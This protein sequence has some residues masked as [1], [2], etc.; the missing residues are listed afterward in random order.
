MFSKPQDDLSFDERLEQ[1]GAWRAKLALDEQTDS[2]AFRAWLDADAANASAWEESQASWDL[3]VTHGDTHQL[4]DASRAARDQAKADL[5]RRR[6]LW[7]TALP[8]A[9]VLVL[10]F[11]VTMS[12]ALFRPAQTF[13]TAGARR[14]VVLSD[15]STVSLDAGT[16]L[17][18]R[19]RGDRRDLVLVRGQ[20]AFDVAHDASRP[21]AVKAGAQRVTALGTRFNIDLVGEA[22]RITLMEG[23]VKVEP[24]AASRV[25][26]GGHYGIH[27]RPG[28]QLVAG[29][30]DLGGGRAPQVVAVDATKALAWKSGQ[31]FFEDELLGNVVA[32][33]SRYTET[34]VEVRDPGLAQRRI[35][36]MF[37]AGDIATFLD[38]VEHH[39]DAKAVEVS[40]GRVELRRK[41]A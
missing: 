11:V 27:L 28:Q 24:L 41:T 17:E 37:I 18:V 21:F 6:R 5:V 39:L 10:V 2:P 14:D 22:A 26:T 32:R 20:A 9:A 30:S 38:A 40:P 36:G 3:F 35:S 31:L 15:G 29:A 25:S 33:V 34:K 19:F 13:E 16:K 12:A 1:A 4:L 8:W 23:R 7:R